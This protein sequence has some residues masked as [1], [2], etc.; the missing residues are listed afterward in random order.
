MVTAT[1]AVSTANTLANTC[2]AFPQLVYDN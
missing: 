2:N 1:D